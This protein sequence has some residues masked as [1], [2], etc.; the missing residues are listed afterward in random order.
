[1]WTSTTSLP[2][3]PAS[4]LILTPPSP[5]S[6]L[7]TS[8]ASK[9]PWTTPRVALYAPPPA[10]PW[11]AYSR[12][13]P[14]QTPSGPYTRPPGSTH[15]TDRQPTWTGPT[16]PPPGS[17]NPGWPDT[18]PPPQTT[19]LASSA[20]RL[21]ARPSC[22]LLPPRKFNSSLLAVP[23]FLSDF[24]VG[25]VAAPGC[26]QTSSPCPGPASRIRIRHF[27]FKMY[28]YLYPY[29]YL[30]PCACP[31]DPLPSSWPGRARENLSPAPAW[32]H[33][34]SPQPNLDPVLPISIPP[35]PQAC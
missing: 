19:M 4:G 28:R 7:G 13:T 23:K 5:L 2:S 26:C 27:L 11:T 29:R 1:M 32:T 21:L 15:S 14:T 20:W 9:T 17:P 22:P 34:G 6:S 12:P 18:S 10:P 3:S 35:G 33:P 8:T 25:H 30:P 24:W 16:C 31:G